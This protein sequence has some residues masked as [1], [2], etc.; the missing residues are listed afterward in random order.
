MATPIDE[1][2]KA[3]A[4]RLPVIKELTEKKK[5]LETDLATV[6]AQLGEQQVFLEARVSDVRRVLGVGNGQ[7]GGRS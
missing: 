6:N 2:A 4:E 1:F 3:I 5:R 7:G